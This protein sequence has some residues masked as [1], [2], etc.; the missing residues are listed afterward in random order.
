MVTSP[1][2]EVGSNKIKRGGGPEEPMGGDQIGDPF[3]EK[4]ELRHTQVFLDVHHTRPTIPAPC[5]PLRAFP[6]R[7]KESCSS[8]IVHSL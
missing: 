1:A 6:L 7:R 5:R 4:N 2:E 8:T 3:D